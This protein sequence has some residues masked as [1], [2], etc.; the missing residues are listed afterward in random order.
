MAHRNRFPE[1]EPLPLEYAAPPRQ[2]PLK[3][4][5]LLLVL[6]PA[7]LVEIA[8][9]VFAISRPGN[10]PVGGAVFA[11][12]VVA[13][14]GFVAYHGYPTARWMLAALWVIRGSVALGA[15]IGKF[16]GALVYLL[17]A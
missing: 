16:P 2:A 12:L 15:A 14:L 17:G 9:A 1:D 13:I 11:I 6:V 8:L 3:Q 4:P 7:L 5:W 10:P